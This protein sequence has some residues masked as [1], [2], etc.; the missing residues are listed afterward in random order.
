M[1]VIFNVGDKVI[2]DGMLGVI[3]A[4]IS[5]NEYSSHHSK[6]DWSYLRSG[7]LIETDEIGLVYFPNVDRNIEK[8]YQ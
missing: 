5:N 3:V 4:N 8:V 2:C 1:T 7:I 6:E